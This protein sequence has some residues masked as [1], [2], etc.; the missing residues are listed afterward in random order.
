MVPYNL[1]KPLIFL[2]VIMPNL[3]S[4]FRKT[5]INRK[6]QY[7]SN[8]NFSRDFWLLANNISNTFTSS[9]FPSLHLSDAPQLSLLSLKLNYSLKPLLSILFKRILGIF[10][11]LFYPLTNSY[12]KLKFLIMTFSMSSLAL[13]IRRLTVRRESILLFSKTVLPNSLPAWSN[14]FVCV[15][16]FLPILLTRSL[17]IVNP[18]LKRVNTQM[19]Q[20]I[21]LE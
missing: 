3:F 20:N 12:L 5:F 19:I 7:L 16:L 15:T 2:P 18:F 17:L 10:F 21:A 9:S 1:L 11:L 4:K 13:I 8:S 14:S 6:C